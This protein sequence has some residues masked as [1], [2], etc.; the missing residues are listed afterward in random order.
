MVV[1]RHR[2]VLRRRAQ[3]LADRQDG[4]ADA[5]QVVE[6]GHDLVEV[7]AQPH[8]D[9]GLGGNCRLVAARPIEQ[10]Q[11]ARIA[12]T[13]SRH[14]VE[15][16]HGFDVVV[17]D[18]G[19]ASS[20]ASQ[21]RFHALE[22]GNQHFDPAV[23]NPGARLP[24]RLD[25]H[26]RAAVGEIV[27]VDRRDHGMAQPHRLDRVGDPRRLRHVELARPP[28]RDGA[29]RAGARADVAQDHERRR[30]VVPALADVGA[31]R[32]LAD[33][34]ELQLLHQPLEAQIV[35]R[36]RRAHLEPLGLRL[37]GPDELQGA[38]TDIASTILSA[39][40]HFNDSP[41]RGSGTARS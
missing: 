36:P 3:V 5:P 21:R 26:R 13:G 30:A 40:C 11:R 6:H 35:L 1:A 8:H 31:A 17:E 18:V 9:A 19:P 23:R 15:P 4:D 29:V 7:L 38:S 28:V 27:A 10:L 16:R 39:T 12:P 14:P 32:L 41:L 25:E 22:V 34:V 24:D 33:G 2:R 37:A 20:T